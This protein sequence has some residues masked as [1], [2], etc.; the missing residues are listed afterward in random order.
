MDLR[1]LGGIVVGAFTFFPL[2][3]ASVSCAAIVGIEDWEGGAGGS[4]AEGPATNATTGTGT[5]PECA[6]YL[7]RPN[8]QNGCIRCTCDGQCRPSCLDGQGSL[9]EGDIDCG[10]PY[11]RPCESG[12]K[13]NKPSDCQSGN[14]S[15]GICGGGNNPAPCVDG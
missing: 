8:C 1:K 5:D 11:C 2:A 12:R 10:G 3:A 14:C 4:A 7:C 15:A 13:C 6:K 9:Q